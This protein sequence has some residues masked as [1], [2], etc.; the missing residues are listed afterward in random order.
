MLVIFRKKD[1]KNIFLVSIFHKSYN[2]TF[3]KTKHLMFLAWQKAPR[4]RKSG[5]S[6]MN[7]FFYRTGSLWRYTFNL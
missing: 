2:I 7:A 1:G 3:M 5:V 6:F 4:R